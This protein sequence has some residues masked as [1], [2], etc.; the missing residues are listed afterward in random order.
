MVSLVPSLTEA[1]AVSRPELLIGATDWCS[2]PPELE[3]S[4]VRGTKN[5]DLKRIA[6]L[7]PDRDAGRGV[8]IA[9][10]AVH[11]GA[12]RPAAGLAGRCRAKLGGAGP[13]AAAAHRRA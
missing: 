7:G 6:E 5:P 9:G 1:I 4:R 13:A 10:P 3:V 11:P 8:P 12:G 2:Q